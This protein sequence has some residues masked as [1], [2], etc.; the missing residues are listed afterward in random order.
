MILKT[1]QGWEHDL[2]NMTGVRTWSW[3]HD[4]GENMILKTWQVWEHDPE[5]MTGVRTWSWKHDRGQNMILKTWQGWEQEEGEEK[6]SV[7]C[8]PSF[9]HSHTV[10][11]QFTW[12]VGILAWY[13]CIDTTHW[14]PDGQRLFPRQAKPED[15]SVHMIRFETW[16]IT[17]GN[18]WLVWEKIWIG[19]E[20][21]L[22][23]VTL[24]IC[25]FYSF[26]SSFFFSSFLPPF[27][28]SLQVL[29]LHWTSNN[30][31]DFF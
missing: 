4:R 1:W 2:E 24:Y 26:F 30:K 11:I 7:N 28:S 18:H 10:D 14:S 25:L 27:F 17:W 22:L 29:T 6:K 3:K 16:A 9:I 8:H 21:T 20:N 5:N 12:T 23:S 15:W 31:K 19:Y 13:N